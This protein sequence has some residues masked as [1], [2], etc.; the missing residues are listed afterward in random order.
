MRAIRSCKSA[1]RSAPPQARALRKS[2]K[3]R[4]LFP[5][6]REGP[7]RHTMPRPRVAPIESREHEARRSESCTA[8]SWFP[9]T[10]AMHRRPGCVKRS[11][12]PRVREVEIRLMH[13]VNEF[14]LGLWLRRCV[15]GRIHG[16]LRKA[17][18]NILDA[19]EG[20]GAAGGRQS[21][22]RFARVSR[23]PGGRDD[24]RGGEGVGRTSSSWAPMDAAVW[25]AS[26]WEVTP[27]QSCGPRRCR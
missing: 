6:V 13:V 18:R 7:A 11:R 20:T 26:S 21:G 8:K 3:R 15:R 10:A 12:S 27:R 25:L 22:M 9:S 4:R 5:A 1:C 19:A 14:I 2:R 16:L 24:S 17:G 23:R